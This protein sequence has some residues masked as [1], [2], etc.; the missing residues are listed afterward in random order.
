MLV[1]VN[2]NECHLGLVLVLFS[3]LVTTLHGH[4]HCKYSIIAYIATYLGAAGG[5]LV[6]VRFRVVTLV[7]EL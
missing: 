2:D 6:N 7:L 1:L 4:E 5:V 3:M